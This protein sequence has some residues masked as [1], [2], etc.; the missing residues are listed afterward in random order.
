MT[1]RRPVLIL[2]PGLSRHLTAVWLSCGQ[3]AP[4]DSLGA[5]VPPKPINPANHPM[6]RLVP[7]DG[8]E[9]PTP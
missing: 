2:A 4:Q 9:P 3:I 1:P 8:L 7:P 6:I 5:C